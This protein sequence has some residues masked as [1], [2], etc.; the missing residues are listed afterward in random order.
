[1]SVFTKHWLD[2]FNE[3]SHASSVENLS[4]HFRKL[5]FCCLFGLTLGSK[6]SSAQGLLCS[7]ATGDH[8]RCWGAS[9]VGTN[10]FLKDS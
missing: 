2:F 4:N 9:Y 6:T 1:M 5:I 7:G 8:V 3:C 10:C